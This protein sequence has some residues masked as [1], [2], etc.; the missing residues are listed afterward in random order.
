MKIL[1]LHLSD[2]HIKEIFQDNIKIDKIIKAVK[3]LGAANIYIPIC[4]GDLAYSGKEKEYENVKNFLDTLLEG[5][6]KNEMKVINTYLV[7][8]NHDMLFPENARG[9]ADILDYYKNNHEDEKFHAELEFQNFFFNFAKTKQ[10]FIKNRVIDS[11]VV[12]Y[13]NYIIQCN[14]I[15]TAP[16]STLRPDNKEIHNL[17]EEYLSYL[18]KQE[19]ADLVIT[20][21]HHSIEWFHDKSKDMLE[22][23]LRGHSDIVFQGH[24]H[25][26]RAM[27]T[28]GFVLSKGGEYSGA[29]PHESTFSVL[30]LDTESNECNE[31]VFE[32]SID[33]TM[34]IKKS[35]YACFNIT[36]KI[37]ELKPSSSFITSFF[38]D[39][40]KLAKSSLD[41]F[42]FPKLFQNKRSTHDEGQLITEESFWT[43]LDKR[44]IINVSGK[45]G[46]G[47][48][49]FLKYIFNHCMS[50]NK[51]PLYL[52]SDIYRSKFSADKI[53]KI[54]F[55]EQYGESPTLY[56]KFEQE[57]IQSKFLLIDDFDLINNKYNQKK[58]IDAMKDKVSYIIFT[59]QAKVY[60]DPK[61]MTKDEL[62]ES[63]DYYNLKIDDF[64]KE[65]RT[66]LVKK[67]CEVGKQNKPAHFDY[68]VEIIDRLVEK[69][70]GLFELSP[71]YIV[72]YVKFFLNRDS[73]D[74]KGEAVFNVVFETN[75]RNSI[76]QSVNYYNI[77]YCLLMLEEVAFQMHKNKN[78]HIS[79]IQIATIIEEV[80]LSRGLRIDIKKCLDNVST[81]RILKQTIESNIFEFSNRNYLAYFIAKKL[82]KLIEKNGLNISELKYIYTNICFGINDNIL[83]FLS[84]LRD[85]TAFA[86]NICDM[87][88][89]VVSEYPELDFDGNNIKFIKQKHEN[90]V[91]IPTPKE[92]EEINKTSDNIE[93]YVRER[94]H[95]EIQFKGVYDY[96]ENAVNTF[97]NK[98]V[99]AVK[100]LEIISKSL[101]S[102][103]V[104]LD[105]SEKKK[106]INL[107]YSAPNRLLYALLKPHDEHYD[108]LI[109]ELKSIFD[110]LEGFPEISKKTIEDIF[111][112]SAISICLSLY[113]N[114][115]FF[116]TNDE[117]LILLNGYDMKNLNYRIANLIMEEHSGSTDSFVRKAIDLKEKNQKDLFTIHLI[118]L[119]VRKHIITR[120][121]DFEMKDRIADKI[122]SQSSKKKFLMSSLKKDN[123]KE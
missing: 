65:K 16:F 71:E 96:D 24:E 56:E 75:I 45:N 59:S 99:R 73:D 107:M 25:S 31:F 57:P 53:L 118:K 18:V 101:I 104:N 62:L 9:S 120:T 92:K 6:E 98:M 49:T 35:E 21:M 83:L 61:S 67:I 27:Q 113:D 42:V 79:H 115:A 32:W 38:E 88:E 48:T 86:L 17:P 121:V 85:N 68:I 22:K 114:I 12:N 30:I 70:H 84:F 1:F 58:L 23:M 41:Y 3:S 44:R 80:N 105:L 116:G 110:A 119:I 106:I 72:Q 52:G 90:E 40:Q 54:L 20:V 64:Y 33:N 103:F 123:K 15:N 66:E 93:K 37:D 43:V 47:K 87:L 117:T 82:N 10:C 69:R 29:M 5:L 51:F 112:S 8:G 74:R 50:K 89:T 81:A 34:F 109:D 78:G 122:F 7:P 39:T 97:Q 94:E 108:E 102:H 19:E 2:L 11:K 14:L 111:I 76:L 4:S 13:D 46:S 91:S 77:E 60:L 36:R 63:E 55:E 28:D 95:E 100:Y 26:A